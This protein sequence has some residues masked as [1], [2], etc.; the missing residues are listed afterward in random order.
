MLLVLINIDDV[1]C[2]IK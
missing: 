2:N 1:R